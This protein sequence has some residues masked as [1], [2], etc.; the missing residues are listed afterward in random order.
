M[1]IEHFNA[2]RAN[3][4]DTLRGSAL[5]PDLFPDHGGLSLGKPFTA[6]GM[7]LIGY[8]RIRLALM[9]DAIKTIALERRRF[10]YRQ[11]V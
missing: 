4:E 1:E 9:T 11:S 5:F 6:R 3:T 7:P 2:G 8:G 10:G